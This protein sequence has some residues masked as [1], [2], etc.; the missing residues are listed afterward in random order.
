MMTGS[1]V[2]KM[3]SSGDDDDQETY[4]GKISRYY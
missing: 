3:Q 4:I 1:F 2:M